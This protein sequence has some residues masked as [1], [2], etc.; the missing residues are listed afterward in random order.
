MERKSKLMSL[1]LTT[2]TSIAVASWV[3]C[4]GNEDLSKVE[5][6][7]DLNP[8][9]NGDQILPGAGGTT[10]PGAGG[11]DPGA[12]PTDPGAGPTDPGAGPTDPAQPITAVVC[13]DAAGAEVAGAACGADN[14]CRD[15]AGNIVEGT[16]QE[17]TVDPCTE[18]SSSLSTSTSESVEDGTMA[19]EVIAAAVADGASISTSTSMSTSASCS[20]STSLSTSTSTSVSTDDA[21]DGT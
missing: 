8:G 7:P 3:G 17:V 15:A 21:D 18:A 10:D 4:Y 1:V 11:T 2:A 16:C 5:E 19:P 12:G 9:N 14:L 13:V 6:P 20:T